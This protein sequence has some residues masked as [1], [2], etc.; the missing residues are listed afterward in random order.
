MTDQDTSYHVFVLALLAVV[1]VT[2]IVR[3]AAALTSRRIRV[4]NRHFADRR[5]RARLYW[6]VVLIHGSVLL[7]VIVVLG[8]AAASSFAPSTFGMANQVLDA[9]GVALVLLV[10]AS[11][12]VWNVGRR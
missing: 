1:A 4:W 2:L 8:L 5:T 12:L 6:S 11:T 9:V 7:G 10:A 3:L